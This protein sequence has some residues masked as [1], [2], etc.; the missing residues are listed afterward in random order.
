M[1]LFP[2]SVFADTITDPNGHQ[3]RRDDYLIGNYIFRIETDLTKLQ[4][5]ILFGNNVGPILS[6][7]GDKG[8]TWNAIKVNVNYYAVSPN[9]QEDQTI[10]VNADNKIL[11]T[12]DAGKKFY[13]VDGLPREAKVVFSPDYANDNTLYAYNPNAGG[14]FFVSKDR[15][16]HWDATNPY[17]FSPNIKHSPYTVVDVAP[18]KLGLV[19]VLA[20][21]STAID[22]PRYLIY[23]S[24]DYGKTFTEDKNDKSNTKDI[25]YKTKPSTY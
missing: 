25:F 23:V 6:Y 19:S 3:I 9:F 24:N 8:K 10:Y 4:Q 18:G 20:A 16:Q 14:I 17:Q 12:Q 11:V 7:S 2:G 13:P 15:G 21:E 22:N 1:L 5:P